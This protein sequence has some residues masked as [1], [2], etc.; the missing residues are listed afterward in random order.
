MYN[1]KL[2]EIIGISTKRSE[3]AFYKLF[4]KKIARWNLQLERATNIK[5]GSLAYKVNI[6]FKD[7]ITNLGM[8]K[9]NV[10]PI[11][12]LAFITSISA[13][14]SMT[15]VVWSGEYALALPAFGAIFYFVI[16]VFR[17]MSLVAYEKKEA[18]IM[19]TEDLIAMD[20]KGGVYNAILRYRKSLHPNMRPYFEEFVDNISHKGYGFRDAMVLLNDKLG[21]TFTDFAQ[22]AIMYEEKA[23]KD[24]DD[25]FSSVVEVNR[26]KRT[27]RYENN[28]KFNQLRLEFLVSI[29][30]IGLYGVFSI[31]SDPF[32]ANFFKNTFLGKILLIVDVVTVTAVLAYISSIKAKFL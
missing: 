21:K 16:V 13:A 26:Y 22:K 5:K 18:E 28:K 3:G 32:L 8:N 29:L 9:D 15:Y 14:V 23:D 10:T 24:M 30:V 20:I 7:I 25:I 11:G 17:F 2:L 31:F 12:L 27:L 19:D 4:G 6:Y 1:K